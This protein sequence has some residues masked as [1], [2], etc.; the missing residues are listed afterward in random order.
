MVPCTWRVCCRGL[1][2]IGRS[3]PNRGTLTAVEVAEIALDFPAHPGGDAEHFLA[4]LEV[5]VVI[6]EGEPFQLRQTIPHLMQAIVEIHGQSGDLGRVAMGL[7]QGLGLGLAIAAAVQI[8][9]EL[10]H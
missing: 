10:R 3:P 8:P 9:L 1:G 7:E 4:V 5:A 2:L 6:A